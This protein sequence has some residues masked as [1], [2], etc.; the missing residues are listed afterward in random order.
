[1]K[2]LL[3]KVCPNLTAAAV[4]LSGPDGDPI[5]IARAEALK[6]DRK[7]LARRTANIAPL[8]TLSGRPATIGTSGLL[9][10]LQRPWCRM[11]LPRRR[12]LGRRRGLCGACCWPARACGASAAV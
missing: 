4:E 6:A 11:G 5:T 9:P 2:E 3:P 1:M 8:P 7:E 10:A 12:I